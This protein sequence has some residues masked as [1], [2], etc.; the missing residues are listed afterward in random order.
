MKKKPEDLVAEIRA[1]CV[2]QQDLRKAG[3]WARYFREGYGGVGL[4]GFLKAGELLFQSGKYQEGALAIRFL[5]ER[6]DE[7]DA[8]SVGKLAKWF[9]AGIQNWAHTDVL[10]GEVIAP[11]LESRQLDPAVLAG[12]R[13][14]EF[15][16]QRRAVPVAMLGL[17][18]TQPDIRAPVFAAAG[19]SQITPSDLARHGG[20]RPRRTVRRPGVCAPRRSRSPAGRLAR[21]GGAVQDNSVRARDAQHASHNLAQQ[22]LID[23]DSVPPEAWMETIGF[24]PC[25]RL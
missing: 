11:L 14:S 18:K 2:A 17:L 19:R 3:K 4:S 23:A 10:C 7:L 9:E 12:W 24:R 16:Y 8:E 25:P 5:K 22:G 20:G 15:K 13:E 6:R 1:Y 21:S